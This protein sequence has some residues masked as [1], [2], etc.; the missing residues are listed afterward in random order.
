MSWDY[1]LLLITHACQHPLFREILYTLYINTLHGEMKHQIKHYREETSARSDTLS[2]STYLDTL[3]N[4]P[5]QQLATSCICIP[6]IEVVVWFQVYCYRWQ[7]MLPGCA[8]PVED[9]WL[10]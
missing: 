7:C 3:T 9:V 4:K 10:K 2:S 1:K 6:S 8:W 5:G